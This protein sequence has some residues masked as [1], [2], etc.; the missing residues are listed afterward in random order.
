[1]GSAVGRIST[2]AL[3]L[4][5]AGA[6]HA[7]P[8]SD[9]YKQRLEPALRQIVEEQGLPGLALGVIDEGRLVYAGGFGG[10]RASADNTGDALPYGVYH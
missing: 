2:S 7:Q 5:A 9:R 8:P 3:M 4:V 1:M 10:G 6:L